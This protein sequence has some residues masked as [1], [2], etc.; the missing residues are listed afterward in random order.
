[1]STRAAGKHD[2]RLEVQRKKVGARR[3]GLG[4]SAATSVTSRSYTTEERPAQAGNPAG[5]STGMLGA[6]QLETTANGVP[7]ADE[8]FLL[9]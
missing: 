5:C 1:M 6:V 8:L 9:N 7:L 3:Q 4:S 2:R